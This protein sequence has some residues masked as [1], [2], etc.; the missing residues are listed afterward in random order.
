MDNLIPAA[1]T[2]ERVR[3][4]LFIFQFL[5]QNESW[6]P[7]YLVRGLNRFGKIKSEPKLNMTTEPGHEPA[8]YLIFVISGLLFIIYLITMTH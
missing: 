3:T 1:D 7:F 8:Y 5:N 4:F 6:C 2:I